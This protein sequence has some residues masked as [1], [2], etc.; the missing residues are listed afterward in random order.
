LTTSFSSGF[1]PGAACGTGYRAFCEVVELVVF[2]E[3]PSREVEL[4]PLAPQPT[5]ATIKAKATMAPQILIV[6]T[7]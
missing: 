5:Q 3:V 6:Q 7:L 2:E 1:F 4:S